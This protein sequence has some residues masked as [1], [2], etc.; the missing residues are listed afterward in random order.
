M[1]EAENVAEIIL[2]KSGDQKKEKNQKSSS[3]MQQIIETFQQR[4]VDEFLDKGPSEI[5]RKSE[6]N[7]RAYGKTDGRENGA[8]NRTVEEPAQQS[9]DFSRDGRCDYLYC[10]KQ[11]EPEKRERTEGIEEVK[12]FFFVQEKMDQAQLVKRKSNSSCEEEENGDAEP[13][14]LLLRVIYDNTLCLSNNQSKIVRTL[15]LQKVR[16]RPGFTAFTMRVYESPTNAGKE[17]IGRD[18]HNTRRNKF[19]PGC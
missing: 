13:E 3:V 6:S 12:Q 4:W 1:A 14:I 18:V 10:L 16:R 7:I 11:Y 2:G 19:H 15:M 5:P 9:R 17:S 8:E